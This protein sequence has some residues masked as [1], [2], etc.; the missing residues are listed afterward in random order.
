MSRL[1]SKRWL[2]LL[3][4]ISAAAYLLGAAVFYYPGSYD[5][6]P[7]A[8][9]P[10]DLITLPAF[11]SRRHVE[12]PVAR[13]GMLLLEN[14][15]ANAFSP[16]ELDS[17]VSKV[18]ARG[19]TVEFVLRRD[20]TF[21]GPGN[22]ALSKLDKKLHKARSLAIV[23]PAIPF[24]PEELDVIERF[25]DKGGRLLLIGDPGRSNVINS[26][27]DRFGLLFQDGYLYNV[28]DHVF[29]F[30]NI[31][32][33]DFRADQLTEGLETVALF[34][35]GSIKST[36]R[37]LA[38]ADTNTF[39][40]M[41]ERVQPF[42]P[43]VK[44]ADGSILAISDLTFMLPP[45]DSTLDNDRLISN[46]AD[47]VTTGDRTFDLSDFPHFFGDQVDILVGSSGLFDLGSRLKSMLAEAQ[48][49]SDVRGVE[50]LSKDTLFVGLYQD[51]SDVA[52]YLDAAG[53]QVDSALRT[54][55]T[56]DIDP[57][58]TAIALLHKGRDRHVMVILGDSGR[59]V[60]R[61]TA[62]LDSGAFRDGLVGSHLGVYSLP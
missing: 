30:R 22:T 31:I 16:D 9:V 28:V 34:N 51:S 15:H 59:A 53:V 21:P 5:P 40:S 45:Q 10:A 7:D 4:P 43:I 55:F 6:P 26:V 57:E 33:R 12:A 52:Q 35:A 54:P 49:D 42:S 56:P 17:L 36:G 19:Y 41:V 14:A 25:M 47:F 29:N 1:L 50:D 46:I 11:E 20:V 39:S 23:L 32:V 37:P 38:F 44:S 2:W 18:T 3:L 60:A 8:G 48:V 27:A 24:T 61:L 13:R 58:G 62:M